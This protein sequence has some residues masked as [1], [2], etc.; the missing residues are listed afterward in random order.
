LVFQVELHTGNRAT[1]DQFPL[2]YIRALVARAYLLQTSQYAEN[3]GF[4][5]CLKSSDAAI[6]SG[7]RR[8]KYS[9][10]QHQDSL[11]T[12]GDCRTLN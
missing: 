5:R 9:F 6:K 7:V 3:N 10:Q 4:N 1:S 2:K 11:N 8:E 12:G